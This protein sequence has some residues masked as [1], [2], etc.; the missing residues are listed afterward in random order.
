MKKL[1]IVLAGLVVMAACNPSHNNP[2]EGGTVNDGFEGAGDANGGIAGDSAN[3]GSN[4]SVDT[5][6]GEDRVDTE[7]RDSSKYPLEVND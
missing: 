5:A 2:G 3:Y 4:P 1:M 7:Q 6:V